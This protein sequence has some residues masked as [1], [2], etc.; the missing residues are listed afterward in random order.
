M[1]AKYA[2]ACHHRRR[3]G[4]VLLLSLSATVYSASISGANE[5]RLSGGHCST[6]GWASPLLKAK[7][8]GE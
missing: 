7:V 8:Y 1:I 6:R 3:S 2:E 4:I 5:P